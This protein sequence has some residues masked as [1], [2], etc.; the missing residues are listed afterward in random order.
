MEQVRVCRFCGHMVSADEEG[1]CVNCHSFSG[2]V[3]ISRAEAERLSRSRKFGFLRSRLWLPGLTLLLVAFLAFWVAWSYLGL[4]PNPR[5]PATDISPTSDPQDWPQVR[6]AGDGSGSTPNPVPYPHRIKWS[7]DSG[8]PLRNAPAVVGELL[9]LTTETGKTVALDQETGLQVWEY[10]TG[11]PSSS[12]PAVVTGSVVF[13]VRPGIV[14]ALDAVTGAMRWERDLKSPILA[15]PVVRNGT[16]YIG[17]GDNKLY[18][19]DVATG[20][21]LWNFATD[22]W[23]VA[24]VALADSTVVVVSKDNLV[25]VV[26]T[27]TARRRL[28]YD[29][30]RARQ[31]LGGPATRGDLVYVGSQ[32]GRVWAINWRART[33]PWDRFILFWQTTFHIW[34]WLP[35]PPSQRGS[36]WGAQVEGDVAQAPAVAGD[37]VYVAS[38]SGVVTALGAAT[39]TELWRA[40]VGSPVTAAPTVAGP[41]V[42][43]GTESG[44]V[45]ALE[46]RTGKVSWDFK[47]GGTITGSPVVAGSTLY[48]VSH[49][50]RLYALEASP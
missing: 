15:S 23:V 10:Q 49:D 3:S 16:V 11:F 12:S 13:A 18:A 14:L 33:L 4:A 43:V 37:T 25:H 46:A 21:E 5:A 38:G 19:L 35:N 28:V 27:D 20:E 48:I 50:G 24:P 2:M 32:K 17:V 31:I 47:T 1:R 34:G 30:G 26:D 36:V 41:A 8:G 22:D 29:T 44:A 42:L 7:Y 6:R 39:G 45:I 9:Y 40:E